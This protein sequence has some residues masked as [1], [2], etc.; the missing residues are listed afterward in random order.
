MAQ[1]ATAMVPFS[2]NTAKQLDSEMLT[3]SLCL[4]QVIYAKTDITAGS[5]GI[6]AFIIEK[7]M[8]GYL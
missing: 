5:K 8:P 7:G 2:C 6:T 1:Y 4:E 3:G